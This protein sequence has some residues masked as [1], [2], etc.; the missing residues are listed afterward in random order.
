MAFNPDRLRHAREK[1]EG[2]HQD[3][4][5]PAGIQSLLELSLILMGE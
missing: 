4:K 3:S 1:R 2:T 5:L